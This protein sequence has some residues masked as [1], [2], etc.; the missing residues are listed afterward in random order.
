LARF[1]TASALA[2]AAPVSGGCASEAPASTCPVEPERLISDFEDGGNGVKQVKGRNGGWYV[3][4]DA[5][6]TQKP[7]AM[8]KVSASAGGACM[9]Q[10]ALTTSGSGF[11]QW[12]AGIGTDLATG[13]DNKKIGYDASEYKGIRFWAKSN[14][15]D[16]TVRLKMQDANTTPEGGLCAADK[17]NDNYGAFIELSGE[18]QEFSLDFSSLKQEGWGDAFPAL[19][20]KKLYGLQF[21]VGLGVDFDFSVDEIAFY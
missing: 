5:T 19:E 7:E 8:K 12:G 15:G 13:P 6:G 10:Y 17:C 21:Q 3:Y 4:N 1:A 11:T 14:K 9:S 16:V 20:A 18:W 2:L